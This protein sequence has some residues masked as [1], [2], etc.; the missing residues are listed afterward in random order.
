[1]K[2]ARHFSAG[3]TFAETQSPVGTVEVEVQSSL[4]DSDGSAGQPRAEAL[5]YFHSVAAATASP[6]ALVPIFKEDRVR[7]DCLFALRRQRLRECLRQ[8]GS[9]FL[10]T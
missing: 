5:G 1:M 7:R 9:D 4:R 3:T 6:D 8:S 2:I 10:P